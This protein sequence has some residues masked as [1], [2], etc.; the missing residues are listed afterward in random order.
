[1]YCGVHLDPGVASVLLV[2]DRGVAS[3]LLVVDPGGAAC[4]VSHDGHEDCGAVRGRDRAG[5]HGSGRVGRV[6]RV[7]RAGLSSPGHG[8]PALPAGRG[9]HGDHACLDVHKHHVAST[10]L[11]GD[12]KVWF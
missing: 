7:G 9:G 4:R 10:T 11:R 12:S 1:M 8:P 2:V 3:V 5:G 6:G